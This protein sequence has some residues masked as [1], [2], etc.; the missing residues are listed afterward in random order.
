M[1]KLSRG[2]TST[3]ATDPKDQYSDGLFCIFVQPWHSVST[4]AGSEKL[5]EGFRVFGGWN[6]FLYSGNKIRTWWLRTIKSPKVAH[7]SSIM[8]E[9]TNQCNLRCITC[10]REYQY[11]EEMAKG[12]MNLDALKK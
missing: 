2:C 3:C 9:V 1:I 5:S 6:F 10:P 4:N 7:P 12:F 8:L 11:G